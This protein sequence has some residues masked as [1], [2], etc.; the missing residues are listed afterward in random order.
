MLVAHHLV[1][2]A[3][4]AAFA[5]DGKQR[6]LSWNDRAERLL[7]YRRRIFLRPRKSVPRKA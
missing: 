1:D 2:Q 6:I 7:D 3:S 4:D 5:I